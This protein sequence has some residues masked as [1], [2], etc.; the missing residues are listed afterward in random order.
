MKLTGSKFDKAASEIRKS[1][2]NQPAELPNI[3]NGSCCENFRNSQYSQQNN[4]E[5]LSH[6]KGLQKSAPKP[7]KLID[8]L[9]KEFGDLT[10]KKPF[11]S[12][13]GNYVMP[14]IFYLNVDSDKKDQLNF[15]TMGKKI[16]SAH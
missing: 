14:K 16:Q 8:S 15:L 6:N 4:K 3:D 10:E 2:K 1:N 11:L 9:E 12:N 5:K 7:I 13:N